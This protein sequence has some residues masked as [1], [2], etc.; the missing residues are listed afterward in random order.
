MGLCS[1][2][3]MTVTSFAFVSPAFESLVKLRFRGMYVRLK[4]PSCSIAHIEWQ[5]SLN[6]STKLWNMLEMPEG[7]GGLQPFY[8]YTGAM[9]VVSGLTFVVEDRN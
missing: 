6:L 5:Q 3:G 1:P 2:L 4:H 7:H 9:V 8:L